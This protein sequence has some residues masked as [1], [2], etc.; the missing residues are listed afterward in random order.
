MNNE[1]DS[2]T[3]QSAIDPI[4]KQMMTALFQGTGIDIQTEVEVS[5]LPLRIDVIIRVATQAALH[6]I[7]T[8]TPF[9]FFLIHNILEFK[10]PG[11][12][13]TIW[14]YDHWECRTARVCVSSAPQISKGDFQHGRQVY[15][16][17]GIHC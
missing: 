15:P 4:F 5:R 9:W 3:G 17:F 6:A 16:Q 14:E 2:E 11:D 8:V 12:P 13:L 1:R 7:Q 10:G